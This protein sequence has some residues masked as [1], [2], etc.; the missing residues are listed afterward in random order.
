MVWNAAADDMAVNVIAKV[1]GSGAWDAINMND[2]ITLGLM[3]WYGT[4]AAGLLTRIKNDHPDQYANIATSLRSDHSA[5]SDSSRW[6][7]TRDLTWPENGSLKPVLRASKDT[8]TQLL[9][10]DLDD[11]KAAAVRIGMSPDTN[12]NAVI[13]F[14]VMYHQTPARAISIVKRTGTNSSLDRLYAA[15]MN[16]PRFSRYK[17]YR[18]KPARDY[19]ASGNPPNIIELN[20]DAQEPGDANDNW[21][22]SQFPE[23][24]GGG[25]GGDIFTNTQSG[26]SRVSVVGNNL[27]V[28]NVDGS[29]AFAYG[30]QGQDFL[31]TASFS[32]ED[33]PDATPAP[34]EE[35]TTPDP[36]PDP[37]S[38]NE[39]TDKQNAIVKFMVD[40]QGRYAYSQGASRL[41]PEKNRSTDCSGLVRF[42]YLSVTGIDVGTYTDAQLS[43]S[44]TRLITSGGGG[45][46]PNE[47][48][49][50]KGDLV[51]SR[52][53]GTAANRS[54]SHVEIYMGNGQIIGHGG[55]MNGPIIKSLAARTADKQ[56]W[57]V[58]RLKDW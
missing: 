49:L 47:A 12:T 19:I 10:D 9:K 34:D 50:K 16:D 58:K 2:P 7:E 21:W 43:S 36:S 39:V 48:L 17:T 32:G 25:G 23:G 8:Q 44:K 20:D 35:D 45:N 52:R 18:Y 31:V 1:E 56:R 57:W 11:Y 40:R 33:V 53:Y 13:Y 37:P 6:W 14:M 3:Q 54:A 28:T 15:S 51:I 38:G 42:A 41:T 27:L 4:R 26:A 30:T 5:N 22:D 24:N 55:P 29:Q 46:S